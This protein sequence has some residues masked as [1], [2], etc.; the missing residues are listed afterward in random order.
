MFEVR[1]VRGGKKPRVV[2]SA[3]KIAEGILVGIVP[4]PIVIPTVE[5]F[6]FTPE[7]LYPIKNRPPVDVRSIE[8]PA[9]FKVNVLDPILSIVEKFLLIFI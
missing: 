5:K 9:L 2:E 8:L 6:L 3:C 7:L 4:S 1:F